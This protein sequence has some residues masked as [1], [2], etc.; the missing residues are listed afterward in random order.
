MPAWCATSAATCAIWQP[1]SNAD[2]EEHSHETEPADHP[3]RARRAERKG[4]R[5]ARVRPCRRGEEHRRAARMGALWRGQ[6]LPRVRRQPLPGAAQR[7][8]DGHGHRRGRGL[9]H[10]DPGRGV[11]PVRQPLGAGHALRRRPHPQDRHRQRGGQPLHGARLGRLGAPGARVPLAHAQDGE[12]DH[13][14][15]GLQHPR[16]P[17]R[18]LPRRARRHGERAGARRELHRQDRRAVPRALRRRRRAHRAGEHGQ[19]LAQ[20][21]AP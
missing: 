5:A 19:L 10:G 18:I 14:R 20:R 15:K 8:S 21:L 17:R 13:H 3:D 4:L 6:H 16:R 9:R 1:G 11:P 7:G 12:P 2:K